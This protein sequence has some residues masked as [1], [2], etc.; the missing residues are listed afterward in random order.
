MEHRIR[1]AGI[2][3]QDENLLLVRHQMDG[4]EFWVPPGGGLEER[5]GGSLGALKREV[6]EETGLQVDAIGPLLFLHEYHELKRDTFH[7]GLIYWIQA[8]Q[9]ELSVH[10]LRGLGGDEHFI[11]EAAWIPGIS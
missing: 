1:A 7:L 11:Q 2:L 8:W 5:D 6:F 9:G 10:N 3:V 4:E